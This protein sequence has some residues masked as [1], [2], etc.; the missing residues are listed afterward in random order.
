MA[1]TL[2]FLPG[3]FYEQRSLVG[4]IVYGVTKSQARMSDKHRHHTLDYC[5]FIIWFEIREH[6]TSSFVLSQDCFSYLGSFV[7][8]YKFCE[9][10]IFFYRNCTESI[11]YL[12][13]YGHFN[14]INSS[15]SWAPYIFS[16]VCIVF[17]FFHQCLKVF[18]VQVFYLLRFIF[19]Y[20]VLF[21]AIVNGIFS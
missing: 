12:G 15:N 18:Q 6:D 9:N 4:Y 16:S 2:T 21:G 14:N 3:E 8:S 20:F 10:A 17:N 11:D 5:N 1:T 13:Y 7:F 19:R